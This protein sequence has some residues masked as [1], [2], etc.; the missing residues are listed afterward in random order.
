[1]LERTH[2]KPARLFY[3]YAHEDGT[4][5]DTLEK[6]LSPL[7]REGLLY[8]WYDSQLLVESKRA[9]EI[10]EHLTTATIILLLISP[11]Y[12]ASDSC[13]SEMQR[14]IERHKRGEA[15]VI[16]II[17]RPCNWQS[18]LFGSLQTLPQDGSAITTWDDQNKAFLAVEQGIRALIEYPPLVRLAPANS[19]V[20][21]QNRENMLQR[22]QKMYEDLLIDSLQE[23]AR[24]ELGL[25]EQPGAVQNAANLLLHRATQ[26]AR[27]L[28]SGTAIL[29]VYQQCSQELLILGEP[30]AGKST[31]LY[32]LGCD[33]LSTARQQ[34]AAPFPI[35]F[36]L[37]SWA[38]TKSPLQ[39]WMVEQLCSPL[40]QIPQKQS[41]QWVQDYQILPLLDGLDEMEEAARPACIAAINTYRRE[42]PSCPLVVCSRSIEYAEA[43]TQERLHLQSAIEVQPLAP[44]QL[45]AIL[46]QT[47]TPFATLHAELKKNTELRELAGNPFWL[48]VM[49]LI[50]KDTS[51]GTLPQQRSALQQQL[52]QQYMARMVEHKGKKT[53]RENKKQ[54]PFGETVRWLSWLAGQMR[55]RNQTVFAVEMLQPDWLEKWPR[56]FYRWSDGL[57]E[58]LL[59]GLLF[60]L[61]VGLIAGPIFGLLVGVSFG[62]LFGLFIGLIGGLSFGLIGGLLARRKD[63]IT[64]AEPA[65]W[66]WKQARSALIAGLIFGLLV[67]LF[68]GLIDG[69]SFGLIFGLLVG[70]IVLIGGLSFGLI[71]EL[72]ARRKD[73]ITLAKQVMWSWE[74]V[75]SEL[76]V[77]PLVGLIGGSIFKLLVG[78]IFGLSV[79]LL[80]GLLGLSVW[81]LV[82]RKDVIMVTER[83]TW[84]W[85]Q[86]RS[87]LLI[88]LLIV[89]LVGWTAGLIIGLLVVLLIVLKPNMYIDRDPLS[90]DESLRRSAK[91]GLIGGLI[92]GL[93]VGLIFGLEFGLMFGLI[94]GLEFGLRAVIQHFLLRFWLSRAGSFPFKAGAFLE[95]ARARHLLH[96]VGG[97][98]CFAHRLLLDS[99]ADL[100]GTTVFESVGGELRG[101]Q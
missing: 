4:F 6:Y 36:P 65:I 22:L 54:Y 10:N 21:T 87:A 27:P 2:S 81:L 99:F 91:N 61:L 30:G 20:A 68:V 55:L 89:L 33:L 93:L 40:Y 5:R 47:G 45:D 75:R 8:T 35:L 14:A 78:P 32:Q 1:M 9:Q 76:L 19:G 97:S 95:D 43:A 60:G 59:I 3:S 67:G 38:E 26:T 71:G 52:S 17:L 88:G 49:L 101:Q 79:W 46:T 7:Q 23:S 37:S 15:Y 34:P 42:Y 51:I 69:L 62:L 12:I 11:D 98:Y 24:I 29:Q 31:L 16:P 96:R 90:P 13:N 66:S 92:V 63:K 74:Q 94:A 85:K 25:K 58:G 56:T 84:S 57:N 64:V 80:V 41:Q 53:G 72:L 86:A 73:K 28:P 44:E 82:G 18:T 70:L 83:V 50:F 100:D 39:E 48:N 77:G